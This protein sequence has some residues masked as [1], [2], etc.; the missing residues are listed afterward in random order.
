MS[1]VVWGLVVG[2]RWGGPSCLRR[3]CWVLVLLVL[4]V[5]L[6]VLPVVL[7]LM[8]VLAPSVLGLERGEHSKK[9]SSFSLDGSSIR[10]LE[11]CLVELSL[12]L[13]LAVAV[14]PLDIM[15]SDLK[16]ERGVEEG[17]AT[18]EE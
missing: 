2:F 12:G 18:R 9:E 17:V 14:V 11:L 3:G 15:I 6:I 5:L 7:L 1:A 10:L 13:L 8:L 4:L 16:R